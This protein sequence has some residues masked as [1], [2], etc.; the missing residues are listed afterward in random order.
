MRDHDS[1]CTGARISF[2]CEIALQC[3]VNEEQSLVSVLNRSPGG[4]G[5]VALC[6]SRRWRRHDEGK[7]CEQCKRDTKS[8]SHSSI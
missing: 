4:V 7:A 5:R 2:W 1:C 3:H 8:I 6:V